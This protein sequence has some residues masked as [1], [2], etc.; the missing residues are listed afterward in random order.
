MNT[1][2]SSNSKQGNTYFKYNQQQSGYGQQQYNSQMQG[3]G[4]AYNN[5][6]YVDQ[7]SQG[8][9]NSYP[10]Q[11]GMGQN[12]YP[13]NMSYQY[14]GQNLPQT[15]QNFDNVQYQQMLLQSLGN[16]QFGQGQGATGNQNLQI[17][18]N[19]QI[20]YNQMNSN[21]MSA[22]GFDPQM[23]LN[24]FQGELQNNSEFENNQMDNNKN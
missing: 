22:Y 14:Q 6:A 1:D 8:F 10:Y 9:Y 18:E 11:T 2:F 20:D 21:L 16:Q 19:T 12:Y 4:N 13:Y 15:N 24:N 23:G 17:G 3:Y 5:N 7:F